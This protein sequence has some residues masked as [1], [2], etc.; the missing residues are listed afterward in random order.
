MAHPIRL[1]VHGDVAVVEID[2]PPVNALSSGVPDGLV[3]ALGQAERDAAVRAVVIMG[4]GR[5]FVAGA[6]IRDLERA[7]WDA[8]VDPP[9]IHD[10]LAR[11]ED[12]SKPVIMAIHGTALGGGLELGEVS[13]RRIGEADPAG[14]LAD[15]PAPLLAAIPQVLSHG[16]AGIAFG[17]ARAALFV[18]GCHAVPDVSTGLHNCF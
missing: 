3:S 10:L 5:T 8:T 1:S 12:A 7:A 14:Q 4:A 17:A 15:G 9:D 11:V 16:R 2:N 6:D 13:R 18:G